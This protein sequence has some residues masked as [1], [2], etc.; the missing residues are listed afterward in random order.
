[1]PCICL[2]IET[3]LCIWC[4]ILCEHLGS[5]YRCVWMVNVKVLWVVEQATRKLYKY[6]AFTK[7]CEIQPSNFPRP[8]RRQLRFPMSLT[9]REILSQGVPYYLH[10]HNYLWMQKQLTASPSDMVRQHVL[11]FTPHEALNA[12]TWSFL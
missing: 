9:F 6:R 10:L 3:P 11:L 8:T 2:Y 4:L 7:L 12:V 5:V 1:M